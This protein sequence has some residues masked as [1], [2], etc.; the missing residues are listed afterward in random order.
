MFPGQIESV[1]SWLSVWY[2]LCFFPLLEVAC[3]SLSEMLMTMSS[4]SISACG[5]LNLPWASTKADL[6]AR[7]D[8][9]PRVVPPWVEVVEAFVDLDEVLDFELVEEVDVF[10]APPA[11]SLVPFPW[12]AEKVG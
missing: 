8:E 7:D 4:S 10:V 6:P 5:F 9:P 11:P 2:S 1:V 12:N 3:P